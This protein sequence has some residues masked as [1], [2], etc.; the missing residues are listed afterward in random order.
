[1]TT[2]PDLRFVGSLRPSQLEIER[3]ARDQLAADQRQLH[4]VAP[5]GSGKTVVGLY[6]WSQLIRKPALVLSP[7]SAI[8]AQWAARTAL[9][10]H[11]NGE[12][13]A[14]S[15][16]T[17]AAEPKLLTSLT[18]QSITLPSRA[19]AASDQLALES[20]IETLL[21]KDQADSRAAAEHWIEDLRTHNEE[22]FNDRLRSYRKKLREEKH[23]IENLHRSSRETFERLRDVGVGL[24]ILDECHHLMGHWGRV[25]AEAAEFL[26]DPIVVGLTATPPDPGNRNIDDVQ[27]YDRFFGDVDY[28]VPVPAIV[29]DGFLAP[30]QDLVY[31]VRPSDSELEFIAEVDQQFAEMIEEFCE[32]RPVVDPDDSPSPYRRQSL[33]DWL[34]ELLRDHSATSSEWSRFFNRDASFVRGAVRFLIQRVGQLPDGV[35]P[36]PPVEIGADTM[37]TLIDRYTRHHLRRSPRP[38]DHALAKLATKRLRM[39]GVQ[40]TESGSRPCASPVSRVMAYTQAKARAL[41]PIM[42]AEQANLGSRIRAVVVAD[43]EK[44]SATAPE[45]SH[46]LNE[47]AGGAVAAFRSI[48]SDDTTNDLDPILVT[49]S[50]VLVDRDLAD[51]F[52]DAARNWL[53]GRSISVTLEH[54]PQGNFSVIKGRG[55]D[56]CPRVYVELITELFQRGLTRCLVGTRGL[57]GEGW[58]A[59][60]VNV[61]VDLS[62][63]TTST[64]VNQLRGRSIRLDLTEQRKLA[65]NWDIVCIA[66]E[67]EQGLA[68]YRRFIRKHESTFGI[69]DDGAIEKGVGHVHA[70]FTELKPD[71]LDENVGYFNDDMLRRSGRREQVYE[72]WQI[73]KPFSQQPIHCIEVRS[74]VIDPPECY[75]PFDWA[76]DPLT[77]LSLV[78]AI[79]KTVLD[80]LIAVKQLTDEH[81]FRVTQRDGRFKRI[82]L[83]HKSQEVD[84][85]SSA[86]FAAACRDVFGPID[87]AR[88]VIPRS[89]EYRSTSWFYQWLPT[90]L[91][92]QLQRRERSQVSLHAVPSIFAS[93]RKLANVYQHQWNRT[94]SPGEA[95]YRKNDEGEQA[96]RA[97]VASNQLPEYTVHEKE[98]FL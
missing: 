92:K 84:Q 34:W 17:S 87:E 30:Y 62:T 43:F 66:P 4:I 28:E 91:I 26:G 38:E 97:A 85:K 20:W 42:Q 71:L 50:T 49:G 81:T 35:P 70:A 11:A 1:M 27:R 89:V 72:Q 24:L 61:L 39:L 67:F 68:D 98:V 78:T 54:Q 74:N 96:V 51:A 22:Y 36:I 86:I 33:L 64:T 9:F 75:L 55:S 47:E 48:L 5:P 59:T 52:V 58:D 16:S 15:V 40:I 31:F 21:A 37:V 93:R 76:L 57:L 10:T 41:V 53:L 83:Q 73:G 32:P 90:R 80:A 94:I 12:L 2:F 14:P 60:S 13:I 88:Y 7:N 8:Q 63:Y 23:A 46:L 44:S 82:Y 25:L 79:G 77:E 19:S 65:N 6:L 45:V 18:Y 95:I 3:I 69:C 56:W 29:K